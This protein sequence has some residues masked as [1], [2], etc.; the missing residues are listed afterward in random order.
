MHVEVN[1]IGAEEWEEAS[2]TFLDS[3]I[4]Q[5][6]AYQQV[7]SKIDDCVLDRVVVKDDTG[8]ARLMA[9]IRVKR[10][11]VMGFRVAYVQW[12][13]LIR[14]SEGLANAEAFRVLR[15]EYLGTYAD[16]LRVVPNQINDERGAAVTEMLKVSG[17]APAGYI[18]VYRTMCVSLRGSEDDIRMRL[19]KRWRKSLNRAEKCNIE[20]SHGTDIDFFKKFHPL[21]NQLR[22][23]KGFRGLDPEVFAQTQELLPETKKMHA[24]AAYFE[25]ELVAVQISSYLGDTAVGLLSASNEKALT[26]G[27]SYR[28]LWRRFMKAKQEGMNWYDLGGIDPKKNPG[29]YRYKARTGAEECEFIG[30]FDACRNAFVKRLWG[31][32]GRLYNVIRK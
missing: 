6:W 25:R 11:P 10:I 30:V 14:R 4:Y 9:M 31:I 27:A 21:Y 7:R 17:F 12:G 19:H 22:E 3:S 28:A 32:G 18:S 15:D 2:S 29:V 26:C 20:I 16:V 23:R 1:Q 13:P 24:V 5:T 8:M